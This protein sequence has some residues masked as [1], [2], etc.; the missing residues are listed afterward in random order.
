MRIIN[1]NCQSGVVP[2]TFLRQFALHLS[3]DD[4]YND[5]VKNMNDQ[6]I[7]S[8]L[9]SQFCSR[10]TLIVLIID[11]FIGNDNKE[12]E[13]V[14]STVLQW[15]HLKNSS[16]HVVGISNGYFEVLS[17]KAKS[18][19]FSSYSYEAILNIIRQ[20]MPQQYTCFEDTVLQYIAEKSANDSGDVRKA[21]E[22]CR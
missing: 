4:E 17:P 6:E 18:V 14:L 9:K 3:K 22:C 1:L 7:L 11:E 2:S 12:W 15:T 20:R 21:L 19:K 16:L 10:D 5:D 13:Y 8:W